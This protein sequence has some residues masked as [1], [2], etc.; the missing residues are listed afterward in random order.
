MLTLDKC[1]GEVLVRCFQPS[2]VVVSV[3]NNVHRQLG[4]HALSLLE[5]VRHLARLA[6]LTE[7]FIMLFDSLLIIFDPLGAIA[8][9][10]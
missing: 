1:T 2:D 3:R 4:V 9:V 7:H 6:I 10:H 5:V 8:I